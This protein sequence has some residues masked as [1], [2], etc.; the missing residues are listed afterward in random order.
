MKA[1]RCIVEAG[2]GSSSKREADIESLRDGK[3]SIKPSAC[4]C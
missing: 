1:R 3:L 4:V 2:I